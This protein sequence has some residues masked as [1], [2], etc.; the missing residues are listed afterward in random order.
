MPPP[1][2]LPGPGIEPASL[3][4]PALAGGFFPTSATWEALFFFTL[5]FKHS[6]LYCGKLHIH[7]ITIDHFIF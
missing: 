5:F 1:G 2:D 7:K 3:M 6:L 4:S